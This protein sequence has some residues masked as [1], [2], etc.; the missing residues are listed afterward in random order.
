MSTISERRDSALAQMPPIAPIPERCPKCTH[1][2]GGK[3][4][5]DNCDTLFP[6]Y[7]GWKAEVQPCA[8]GIAINTARFDECVFCEAQTYNP[9]PA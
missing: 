4:Y 9:W 7:E 1:P 3:R 8:C 5:C 6:Y 2:T